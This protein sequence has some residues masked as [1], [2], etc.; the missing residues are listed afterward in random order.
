MEEDDF[1]NDVDGFLER[2]LVVSYVRFLMKW[3]SQWK[4]EL[5][6]E[7]ALYPAGKSEHAFCLMKNLYHEKTKNT[8]VDLNLIRDIVE[9]DKFSILNI[10]T[11]VNP[12]YMLTKSL[13]AYKFQFCMDLVDLR[14][15]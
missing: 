9:K 1:G 13:P 11:K 10:D 15:T 4:H 7:W 8:D 2:M 5:A 14:K 12:A 6:W 3:Y